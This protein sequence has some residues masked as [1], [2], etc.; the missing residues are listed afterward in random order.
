MGH[1]AL[2]QQSHR[3]WPLPTRPW[4]LRQTWHDLLFLHWPIAADR[5]RPVVPAKLSI[6]EHSGS[7]WV[8]VTPFWMS[9]IGVRRWPTPPFASRFDELNVRTYVRLG[10]R[11]GVWFFSLDAGSL[12][13]VWGAHLLYGLPYVFARMRHHRANGDIAYF[14]KRNRAVQFVARYRPT[15]SP[16][17]SQPGS[18]EHWLTERYCLY[19]PGAS[20]RLFRAEI[21]HAPW[22][23]QPASAEIERNDMLA[24]NG[25]PLSTAPELLHFAERLEVVVWP[26]ERVA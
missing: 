13:G 3:P 1:P 24:A 23:L 15:G 21:H 4:L 7:A 2:A 11:P 14:A 20:G 9:G 10:D 16:R 25:I 22:S 19:A 26:R 8:A 17:Q 5:L 12:L 18:L 6:D